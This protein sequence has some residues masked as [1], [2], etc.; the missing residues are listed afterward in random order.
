MTM[1]GE[2]TEE[3]RAGALTMAQYITNDGLGKQS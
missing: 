2:E 3:I 1:T